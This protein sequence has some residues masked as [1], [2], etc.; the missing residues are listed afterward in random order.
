MTKE[1]VPLISAIGSLLGGGGS[2]FQ[3]F[4]GGQRRA[5]PPAP[6]PVAGPPGPPPDQ[7]SFSRPA[8][9][10]APTFLGMSSQMTPLQQRSA[11]TTRAVSGDESAYRD[12]ATN[13]YYKN[14]VLR[15]V[16]GDNGAV[17]P[18][19]EILPSERQYLASVVGRQPNTDTTESFL[20]ALLR[21]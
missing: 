9:M 15:D 7:T 12:P 10:D 16:V 14:L 21:G 13:E 18:G 8:G 4:G 2:L 20:S 19:A 11:I 6:A 3:A 17:K 5:E 1:I